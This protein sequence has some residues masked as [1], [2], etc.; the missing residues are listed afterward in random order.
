MD[1]A[2]P[3]LVALAKLIPFVFG[4][5]QEGFSTVFASASRVRRRFVSTSALLLWLRRNRENPL[6]MGAFARGLL[7]LR[8]Q[9]GHNR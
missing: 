1:V 8:Q 6:F 3:A 4:A 2:P 9:N 5:A 7:Q